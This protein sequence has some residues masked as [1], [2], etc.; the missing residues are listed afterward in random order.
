MKKNDE[1]ELLRPALRP[2]EMAPPPEGRKTLRACWW[3]EADFPPGTTLRWRHEC[4]VIRARAA[5]TRKPRKLQ[6]PGSV[7]DREKQKA[8]RAIRRM[9]LAV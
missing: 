5:K 2:V 4:A 7:W 9:A 6:K 1:V 8:L 3:R